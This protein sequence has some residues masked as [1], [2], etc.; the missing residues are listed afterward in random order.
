MSLKT[1]CSIF[2]WWE[3]TTHLTPDKDVNNVHDTFV[4]WNISSCLDS[5]L[6]SFIATIF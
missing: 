6:K 5:N 1:H 4:A 3:T 2:I